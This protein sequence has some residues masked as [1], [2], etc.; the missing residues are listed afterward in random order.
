[1]ARGLAQRQRKLLSY[2]KKNP[3]AYWRDLATDGYGYDLRV[4][5]GNRIRDARRDAGVDRKAVVLEQRRQR[6]LIYL[7]DNPKATRKDLRKAGLGS[8]LQ[9]VYR[10]RIN[11]ARRGALDLAPDKY[12]TVEGA[13]AR[14]GMSK[15]KVWNMIYNGTLSEYRA[16][17]TVFVLAS[18]VD[19]L[20]RQE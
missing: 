7:Q 17:G 15:G 14:L 20:M 4:L 10:G 11:E 18:G 2:I 5:Y 1:M 8:D 9:I 13:A 6:V 19:G 12:L 3:D 16:G